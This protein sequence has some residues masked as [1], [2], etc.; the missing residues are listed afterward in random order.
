M[1]LSRLQIG[2][3]FVSVSLCWLDTR[4]ISVCQH[5]FFNSSP[6]GQNGLLNR[7]FR[8][9]SKE[10]SKLRVTGLCVGNWE[11]FPFD[12]VIIHFCESKFCILIKISLKFV[13]KSALTIT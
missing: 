6:V 9:R 10:T 11:M 1:H 12:D 8:G 13:P 7:L 5:I 4:G 3:Y 2:D